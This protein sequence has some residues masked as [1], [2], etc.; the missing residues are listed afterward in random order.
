LVVDSVFTSRLVGKCLDNRAPVTPFGYK[1][2]KS[3]IVTAMVKVFYQGKSRWVLASREPHPVPDLADKS[4]EGHSAFAWHFMKILEENTNQ[5]LLAR[6]IVEPVTN[7]VSDE[8]QGELPCG[9][10]V[11][12]AGDEGGQFVFRL[13]DANDEDADDVVKKQQE[14]F[15]KKKQTLIER[16]KKLEEEKKNRQ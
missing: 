12:G 9:A 2:K 11:S 6:E 1:Y 8:V 16:F 7:R 5:Y 4:K 10:P 14:E 3:A 13:K 15:E